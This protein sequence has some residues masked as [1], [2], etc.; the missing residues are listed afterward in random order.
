[1]DRAA[2]LAA[3]LPAAPRD[4][5]LNYYDSLGPVAPEAILGLWKGEELATGHAYDGL[6]GPSGWWGKAF[7]SVDDVDPL[8]FERRGKRFA[9]NPGL[10]PLG[11]I[12]RAPGLAKSGM[13][14]ALFR[15][16]SPLLRT[17]KSRARLRPVDYRGVTSAAMVYDQLPIIDCFRRVD[18]DTLLGAMDIR[19]FADPYFFVLRRA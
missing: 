9:G 1:M 7:R 11:L 5:V 2:R 6:L 12:E 14:A 3:L 8:V 13:S 17:G 4:E 16:L 10:M 19:G 15:A 18:D